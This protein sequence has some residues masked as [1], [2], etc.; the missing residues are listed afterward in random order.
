VTVNFGIRYPERRADG[1]EVGN[2]GLCQGIFFWTCTSAVSCSANGIAC[3]PA[4]GGFFKPASLV[5]KPQN[6]PYPAGTWPLTLQFK[7]LDSAPGVCGGAEVGIFAGDPNNIIWDTRL[8][9]NILESSGIDIRDDLRA[10]KCPINPWGSATVE[11]EAG[12]L[13]I[14]YHSENYLEDPASL[15]YGWSLDGFYANITTDEQSGDLIFNNGMGSYERWTGPSYTPYHADN[16]TTVTRDTDGTYV[17]TF[18]DHS[19][20]KFRSDGKLSKQIDRNG[21][22]TTFDYQSPS[23]VLIKVTDGEGR[24][25]KFDY[26]SRDDNQ[27]VSVRESSISGSTETDGPLTGFEYN[28]NDRLW[29]ITSPTNEVQT[30][31]YVG[32]RLFRVIDAAGKIAT[33]YAYLPSGRV[34]YEISYGTIKTQRSEVEDGDN[35]IVT[36]VVTDLINTSEP[37]RTTVTTL[38][39]RRLP[40]KV[41]DPLENVTEYQYN[42]FENAYLVT[43]EMDPNLKKT[44]YSYDSRGNLKTLIEDFGDDEEKITTLFY[45]QETETPLP[46]KHMDL[47]TKIVRP[48]VTVPGS[49]TRIEYPPTLLEYDENGNLCKVFDATGNFTEYTVRLS[50]GRILAIK[51]RNG[52]FTDFEYTSTTAGVGNIVDT[53]TNVGNLKRITTYAGPNRTSPRAVTFNYDKFDNKLSSSGPGNNAA[54]YE[55]DDSH[56]MTRVQD[57]LARFTLYNFNVGNTKG[58]LD[59]IEMPSNQGSG[60][61]R[62]T[63]KFFYEDTNSNLVTKVEAQISAS[64]YQKRVGYVF[65]S[66]SRT[67][68]LVRLRDGVDKSWLFGYDILDRPTSSTDP[69]NRTSTTSYAPFCKKYTHT[70]PSMIEH[71]TVMDSL[72]RVTQMNTLEQD[73]T[74][75]YDELGRLTQVKQKTGT[76]SKYYDPASPQLPARFG[77]SRY[78]STAAEE[79][80]SY[81][82]N[83]LDRLTKITYPDATTTEYLYDFEGRVTSVKDPNGNFTLYD[84]Y[85]DDRLYKVTLQRTGFA[86]L[87]FEYSYDAA[88]RLYEI[89]YPTTSG[90]IAKFY[91]TATPTPNSGWDAAGQLKLVRYEKGGADLVKFEYLYDDSGNRT[92]EKKTVGASTVTTRDYTYD[93]FSRLLT[94]TK[95]GA[96]QVTYTY[97]ESDNRATETRGGV[98]KTYVYDDAN[99]LVS[100]TAGGVTENFTHDLDGNMT[101]RTVSGVTTTYAWDQDMRLKR[102]GAGSDQLYD[103]EGIRK[104]TGATSFYSSGAASIADRGAANLTYVQGH[105]IL[106]SANGSTVLYYLHDGLSSV[107]ALANASGTVT[108]NL[109]FDEFGAPVGTATTNPHSYVGGL[110]VRNETSA[111]SKLYYMRQR[112]YASDLGR[113]ISSD[114]IGFAGGLNLYA[115]S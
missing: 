94:V 43:L 7:L 49:P 95:N 88:G 52:N 6:Y 115:Y 113:F 15:G 97:D 46:D 85:N 3:T 90:I 42:D 10:R 96:L 13:S 101:S 21:K 9:F 99:Q 89:K 50:D 82:Y 18:K 59:S 73:R 37:A 62:R 4:N 86:N 14:S 31:E 30:F 23:D 78:Q 11:L 39:R 45:A 35:L 12:G 26:G 110:G 67:K 19:V 40:I 65:D 68:N 77:L 53:T 72:C 36:T 108:E 114:P 100:S 80:R 56:R 74:F 61:A 8:P 75:V 70:S 87:V 69:L 109:D 28:A 1:S 57:A 47:L 111:S 105:Q 44:K 32:D 34:D 22:T 29:K 27:P 55:W 58:Q 91:D 83:S 66:F 54:L 25:Y 38:N 64:V 48:E 106:A 92:Q 93:W 63:T 51:D 71:L 76:D 84:Y 102:I 103:A 2:E 81:E 33:E 20:M 107:R 104:K 5:L 112:W 98:T 41:V 24:G 17:L 16:Y 79:I 60:S